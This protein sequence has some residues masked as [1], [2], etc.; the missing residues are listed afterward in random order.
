MSA[1]CPA[2]FCRAPMWMR[3]VL[4]AAGLLHLA[5][6]ALT[7]G[8]HP[9]VPSWSSGLPDAALGLGLLVA[10]VN[11]LRFWPIV[12]I[13]FA[14]G[15]WVALG[16]AAELVTREAPW[17]VPWMAVDLVWWLPLAAM[18]WAA[19]RNHYGVPFSRGE[20][21]GIQEAMSTYRLSS[22]ESIAGAS[23]AQPLVLVF[24][25]HF[26][27]T[28]TR[29]ILRELESLQ[30]EAGKRG[31]RLALVHMLKGGEEE[32]Y[33][34]GN[35]GVARVADPRCELY[36]AFGLGKAGLLDLFGPR[37]WWLGAIS[38]LKGCGVGHLAGDG[39]QMP[40]T[41]IVCEGRIIAA[42]RA[43]SPAELPDLSGLFAGLPFP[44]GRDNLSA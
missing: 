3:V 37:V 36:R 15:F 14:K 21:F 18:L 31:A 30:E 5:R 27:C 13:A 4:T 20:P 23:A 26:G 9:A 32:R 2:G 33:F 34:G 16:T 44:A 40:G 19:F 11:P 22:G 25:R 12:L 41:F 39:L 42:Q 8:G 10:A 6:F 7:A 35:G 28:F 38:V 17:Q 43:R 29:Q 1:D 24:L